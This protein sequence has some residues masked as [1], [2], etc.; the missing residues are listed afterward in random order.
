M[1]HRLNTTVLSSVCTET[2]KELTATYS[3]FSYHTTPISWLCMMTS[4]SHRLTSIC[5]HHMQ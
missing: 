5:L 4:L 3:C 1:S 2:V